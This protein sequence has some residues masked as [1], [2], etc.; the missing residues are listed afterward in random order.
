MPF[1]IISDRWGGFFG[2]LRNLVGVENLCT[3]FYDDPAFVEEMM[4]ANAG[5]HH[6][7][8]GADSGR[9]RRRR[10]R[11]LGGHGLQHAPLISPEMVRR[12][13]LPRYRRV[14]EF[15]RARGVP[16]VGPGQRRRHATR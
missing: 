15:L 16:Y 11:L 2:P 7:H 13:M 8:H 9:E 3:L 14:T 5:L 4:D 10:V 12:F 1:I 6:R